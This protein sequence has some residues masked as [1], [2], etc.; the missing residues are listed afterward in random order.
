[1][2]H[3]KWEIIIIIS[4][5]CLIFVSLHFPLHKKRETFSVQ[6]TTTI[7]FGYRSF[8]CRKMSLKQV[9]AIINNI[10]YDF[11]IKAKEYFS[12]TEIKQTNAT[13]WTETSLKM[14]QREQK[15]RTG[16]FCSR[17]KSEQKINNKKLMSHKMNYRRVT[18]L[19]LRIRWKSWVWVH[20]YTLKH[21]QYHSLWCDKLSLDSSKCS[22]P[23]Y[24][25]CVKFAVRLQCFCHFA[26]KIHAKYETENLRQVFSFY[27]AW[28]ATHKQNAMKTNKSSARSVIDG[29]KRMNKKQNNKFKHK[30]T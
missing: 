18:V 10:K 6:W 28:K 20:A 4:F 9:N 29:W 16:H 26:A 17:K 13:K 11:E 23:H 21:R 12:C 5:F 27:F 19:V 8:V 24:D 2:T 15:C 25:L 30:Q 7:T 3:N 1:M 14:N 22:R